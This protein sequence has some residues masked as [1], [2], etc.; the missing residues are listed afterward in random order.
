MSQSA[1]AMAAH[2]LRGAQEARPLEIGAI[3]PWIFGV[4]AIASLA[5][6]DLG[7]SLPFNDDWGMSWSATQLIS[8]HQLHIFPVQSALALVQSLVSALLTFGHTDLRWLR[9]S[10]LP[11]VVLAA[12]SAYWISRQL[13]AGLFWSGVGAVCLLGSPLFLT[14]ATTYMS[15]VPYVGLLLA[16]SA[17][18]VAW[19]QRGRGQ[20]FCVVFASLC[21]LQRQLGIMLPL[22]ITAGILVSRVIQTPHRAR[23]PQAGR[24]KDAMWIGA[25]WLGVAMA[26]L[27]PVITGVAPPTQAN[28]VANIIHVSPGRILLPLYFLPA[29]LGLLLTPFCLA[30]LFAAPHPGLLTEGGG[31]KSWDRI[32]AIGL[33]ILAA[34][35]LADL[36]LGL[37]HL[38]WGFYPG[39][40]FMPQGF[41]AS[42]KGDK[43]S[44]FPPWL[45]VAV[46]LVS[47][48]TFIVLLLR[49]RDLWRLHRFQPTD[50]V[51]LAISASQLLPLLLLQTE[52]YDRYYLPVMAPLIPLIALRAATADHQR[53]ASAFAVSWL[54]VGLAMYVAGEADYQAW[55]AARTQAAALAFAQLPPTEVQAGYEA[56]AVAVEIP[57]YEARGIILGGLARNA[58]D[59]DYAVTGPAHP[60]IRLEYARIGDPRPGVDYRSLAASGRIVLARP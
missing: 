6:F 59:L 41:N 5:F 55:Q 56:N 39:N 50:V 49:R 4:T 30:T 1:R 22:A 10:V 21:P 53:L 24:G 14:S 15:D 28:R 32:I 43:A 35:G 34:A 9:L 13:G 12:V 2:P 27:L 29:M 54:L 33:A 36:G 16:S 52:L 38:G 57:V 23:S 40:I 48:A 17:G 58:K 44:P 18:A 11:F 47:S 51:L 45:F 19:V 20:L 60:V 37:A 31:K 46:M 8:K 3:V 42:L 7:P 25:L 26:T